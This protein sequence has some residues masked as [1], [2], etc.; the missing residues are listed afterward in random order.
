GVG[1][2]PTR[3]AL[4]P[5]ITVAS[6]AELVELEAISESLSPRLPA[7]LSRPGPPD[8]SVLRDVYSLLAEGGELFP[9]LVLDPEPD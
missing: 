4:P 5:T 2:G 1:G 9:A 8:S 7:L 3:S 6:E